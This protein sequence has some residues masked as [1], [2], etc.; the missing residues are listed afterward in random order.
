MSELKKKRILWVVYDFY[1]AGG[2]RYVYEICKALNKAKFEID[3]LKIAPVA[4]D[5]NWDT[6]YY[7]EPT[8]ELGCRIFLLE[9]LLKRDEQNGNNKILDKTKKV[10]NKLSS[11]A[12]IQQSDK[13]STI[14]K[15]FLANYD[16]VNFSGLNVYLSLCLANK[17]N[18]ENGIIHILT[19]RFQ[20]K[21][22]IYEGF[23]KDRHY[24]FVSG[25]SNDTLKFELAGFTNYKHT[26]YPLGFETVPY[27]IPQ[28]QKRD[29]PYTIAVFTRLTTM[30]PLDPYFYA[31]KLLLERGV[32]AELR[33]YGAGDPEELGLIRQL[34]Y[35]YIADKVSFPGHV[36]SIPELLK[37][38]GIDLLWF[39]SNNQLP[40]GYAALE[41]AMSGLPQ[42]F[43]DFADIGLKNPIGEVF[44]SFT[45]LSAF[46][47]FSE[48]L[49]NSKDLR[50]KLGM[51]QRNYIQQHN[52]S[53]THIHILEELFN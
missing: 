17:L 20:D 38:A 5:K 10:F 25:F 41:I 52:S 6:E 21:K 45:F 2:Q 31:I 18:P 53:K 34:S 13:V 3:F 32:N 23:D 29:E 12:V 36:E 51:E 19:A 35:L 4:H 48:I 40:A 27:E 44:P 50:N 24:H 39:Q 14:L 46:V 9:D 7:Y 43:W 37:T 22:D 33:V 11:K 15:T 49:L 26:F 30:K 8:L 1:Q 42:I 28:I 47:E 16:H